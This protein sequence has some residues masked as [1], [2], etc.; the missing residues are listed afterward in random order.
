MIDEITRGYL[1]A[2]GGSG[3]KRNTQAQQEARLRNI[4]SYNDM[5][6]RAA[7]VPNGKKKVLKKSHKGLTT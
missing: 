5:R 3:G 6:A 1:S 2:I 7:S 4:Q